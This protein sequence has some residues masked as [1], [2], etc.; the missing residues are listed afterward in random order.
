MSASLSKT[1]WYIE[2]WSAADAD[3]S[4]SCDRCG[5]GVVLW[6]K[7]RGSEDA[8]RRYLITCAHV[9]LGERGHQHEGATTLRVWQPG[10][11]YTRTAARLARISSI[12]SPPDA[13][14]GAQPYGPA[15]DWLLLEVDD[16]SFT[17]AAEPIRGVAIS[18]TMNLSVIGYPAGEEGFS[19]TQVVRPAEQQ[20]F[21]FDALQFGI[22]NLR[23][24]EETRP[25][26]SGGGVF[27]AN[28]NWAG[29]HRSFTDATNL[30]RSVAA[31]HIEEQLTA[32]G[33]EIQKGPNQARRRLLVATA[34][35]LVGTPISIGAYWQLT[36]PE[37]INLSLKRFAED[38]DDYGDR[39]EQRKNFFEGYVNK[40][41]QWKVYLRNIDDTSRYYLISPDENSPQSYWAMAFFED[42][43]FRSE[44][45]LDDSKCLTIDGKITEPGEGNMIQLEY[46]RL[47]D[48]R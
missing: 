44:P 34:G 18:P 24:P 29:L 17:S 31:S 10:T 28:G 40:R 6:L 43:E 14:H 2:A 39:Y 25:G 30:Y 21:R 45:R 1:V 37:Y 41:V 7:R 46:C 33:Y 23:G 9:V 35:L 48:S 26:M 19:D 13:G 38:L 42:S 36:K 16:Q 47:I 5:S 11:G 27:D 12:K 32:R 20:D 4:A 3:T 22:L 15:E 8:G